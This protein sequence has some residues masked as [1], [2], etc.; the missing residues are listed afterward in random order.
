MKCPIDQTEMEKGFLSEGFWVS[1]DKPS[2]ASFTRIGT[3]KQNIWIV[4]WKCPLCG[5]VELQ[6]EEVK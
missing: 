6:A 5:K 4:A 3:G 2:L 1:G